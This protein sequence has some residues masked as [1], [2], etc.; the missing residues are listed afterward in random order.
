LSSL[1]LTGFFS[2]AQPTIEWSKSLGG[3]L[4]DAGNGVQLTSD[5]GYIAYGFANSLDG[6]VVGNHSVN[7]A[8]DAWIVKL[9]AN[10]T[11]E[12][13]KCLGG[14]AYEEANGLVETS[15]G[16]F[17]V[18]GYTG[19][20]NNGDVSGFHGNVDAWL[21]KLASDGTIE[22]QHC[23]G[24]TGEDV[25]MD[26]KTTADGGY[27]F[28][29]RSNSDDGDASGG[30]GNL[31]YWVVKLDSTG[32]IEWQKMMGGTSIDRAEYI[33]QSSDGGY[34]IT[35]YTSSSDGNVTGFQGNEDYWVVKLS[36]TGTLE[37]EKSLG[38]TGYDESFCIKETL[39]GGFILAGLVTSADGDVTGSHGN[40]EAWIVK[41][42]A[43][44]SLQWQKPLG[45][46][47][48]DY[49]T[50]IDLTSDG[51]YIVGGNSNSGDGDAS[52]PHGGY[53]LWLVKL[54]NTGTIEWQKML[55]GASTDQTASKAIYETADN[56]FIMTGFSSSTDGDLTAN[57]GEADAWVVKLAAP[58][59]ISENNLE[60]EFQLV[61]N[62]ATDLITVTTEKELLITVR[63]LLGEQLFL[64]TVQGKT[65][66]DI[67]SL[68]SGVYL[69][70]T[71]NGE[72]MHFIKQ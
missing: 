71:S 65:S 6:D 41:L 54:N 9:T 63:S 59:S 38:G 3:S 44:G 27:V 29:G 26:I 47:G 58:A 33:E 20:N 49:A 1:L 28:C 25:A 21:V 19:S 60:K 40:G 68:P 2:F 24:G 50:A 16:G 30:Q 35:G 55:G 10:G 53:D 45:G 7:T 17:L 37:W 51:G 57:A 61:P 22:W 5:G 13:Q 11:M 48:Y 67:S 8:S 62:P 14:T 46:T 15:D 43:T 18:A 64:K 69:I 12:W 72:T 34:I 32:T 42:S 4:Q 36:S 52:G 70:S 31:D 39:E 56:G 66:I 23:Y